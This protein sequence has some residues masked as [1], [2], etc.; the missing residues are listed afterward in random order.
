LQAIEELKRQQILE[1]NQAEE[2]KKKA[3]SV[4]ELI[5]KTKN[6]L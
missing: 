4:T 1:T 3:E 6:K 5:E 2:E